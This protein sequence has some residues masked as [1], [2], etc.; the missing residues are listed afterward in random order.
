M[1]S[2]VSQHQEAEAEAAAAEEGAEGSGGNGAWPGELAGEV[3][4]VHGAKDEHGAADAAQDGHGELHLGKK[5]ARAHDE[6]GE[7]DGCGEGLFPEAEGVHAP[8]GCRASQHGE[9]HEIEQ[10][11]SLPGRHARVRYA[12][13]AR[14]ALCT[15]CASCFTRTWR[16]ASAFM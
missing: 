5:K 10:Q 3:E 1:R 16:S 14:S 13:L 15:I 9:Q 6:H 7:L 2:L 12:R 11:Q 8:D 4:L